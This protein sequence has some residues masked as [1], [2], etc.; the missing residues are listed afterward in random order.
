MSRMRNT[1]YGAMKLVLILAISS[2]PV[3]AGLLV[4]EYQQ[5]K[6]L[7]GIAQDS[8]QE[9][10]HS[11]DL[12]L[13]RIHASALTALPLAGRACEGV[14]GRLVD[15]VVKAPHLR[16]LA[17]TEGSQVYCSSKQTRHMIHSKLEDAN[18]AFGLLLNPPSMPES[19]LL[20]Y[21]LRE[22]SQGVIATTYDLILRNELRAFRTGLT[23]VLEFGDQYIWSDGDS[24]DA[25]RPSQ[26][27]YFKKGVSAKYGYVVKAGYAEGY[28]AREAR[29][30]MR[31][32]LPALSLIGVTTGAIAYWGLFKLRGN[33]GM[34][35][36]PLT[37]ARNA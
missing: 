24:R 36:R 37:A 3:G 21:Q 1:G 8:V 2:L 10:I 15:Q 26:V 29:Q 20:A 30:T 25:E 12:A 33:R 19:V 27:E 13:D 5:A 6:K 31:Q 23:I 4:M 11:V 22:N 16:S 32:L 17:L 35:R 18:Q 14:R 9:A 7:E 28:A 34:Y